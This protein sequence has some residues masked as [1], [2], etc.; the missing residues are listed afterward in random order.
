M[1]LFDVA[2]K[3]VLLFILASAVMNMAL[4][5]VVNL[6]IQLVRIQF[7]LAV[8]LL[9]AC[10]ALQLAPLAFKFRVFCDFAELFVHLPVFFNIWRD[11]NTF[12]V[13]FDP[14]L[15]FWEINE[16][17]WIALAVWRVIVR[18]DVF[19]SSRKVDLNFTFFLDSI[20]WM[21]PEWRTG[22]WNARFLEVCW[23]GR[24]TFL[25]NLLAVFL[26]VPVAA[27]AWRNL[28]KDLSGFLQVQ[29][30]RILW[31]V[32]KSLFIFCP[33]CFRF[34]SITCNCLFIVVDWWCFRNAFGAWLLDEWGG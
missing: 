29:R 14:F 6:M 25:E 22:C 8:K 3:L 33:W 12:P 15:N 5:W 30:S 21:W 23:E 13:V 2:H 20:F 7:H 9:A 34:K 10:H 4:K 17:R 31:P 26:I 24:H 1:T 28:N 32:K 19:E 16:L 27:L 11:F 18:L